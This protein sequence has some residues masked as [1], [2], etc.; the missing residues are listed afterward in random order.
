MSVAYD[1]TLGV[2]HDGSEAYVSNPFP[3]HG[4]TV[5]LTLRVPSH[6]P[7]KGVYV[8]LLLD[9]EF[10]HRQLMPKHVRGNVHFYAVDVTLEQPRLEYAFKLMTDDGAYYYTTNGISRADSPL[11]YDFVLLAGYQAPHWVRDAV[12]YQIFPDRFCNGNPANDV[13][14]GE[15]ERE[16]A[17]TRKLAWGDTPIPWIKGRSVDFF[18]G[19]LEGITQNLGYLEALGVNALYLTPIWRAASN[20][21]Y[22]ASSFD[23]VDA[24]LGGNSALAELRSAL[25]ERQMR[26]VLDITPNHV[27]VTHDWFIAAQA[28]PNAPTAEHFFYDPE[29][30]YF[31][32][33]LGV[34]SLIKLNYTSPRLRDA[35]YRSESS[36]LR[37][38]L[39]PPYRIDG[40]RL[41]VANMTGNLKM[42]QLD[43]DVWREMRPILK[44]D[45]PNLYLLGE[46]FQD[47]TPHTQGEE[48]DATMNY[49]GFN[50]PM[51]RWL[52]GED[53]GVA[54]GKGW[55]DTV[56]LPS[57]ALAQQ[58]RA[59]MGAV[60]Y[61]IALQQFNQL[62]SH[63][64]TRILHVVEGDKAL[65]VLGIAL[66]MG[67]TGVPCLYYGGEVGMTGGKDPDN[68][69]CML[70][71][72][73]TWDK[74]LLMRTQRLIS[75]RKSSPA[76]KH[77]GFQLLYAEGDT[78]A[79]LREAVSQRVLVV[80]HRGDALA[81]LR[82]PLAHGGIADGTTLFDLLTDTSY[83]ANN[84]TIVLKDVAHG[85]AF[86]LE[87]LS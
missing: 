61:V 21:R 8:R 52:G 67:F 16:G 53:I 56:R 29:R 37:R 32:T 35:M 43:H 63:D 54:D 47:A 12:F 4:E 87:V 82:L 7:V 80:G 78:V 65:A 34:P 86:L 2:H 75:I 46:Y 68:R 27:G 74:D 48:L 26:L 71:D 55:G 70:W 73:S 5:T 30:Q 42:N 84:G 69:R 57:E 23:E 31:E 50:T 81:E 24:H 62:D 39:K 25:D 79:F 58:W 72:E 64:V 6:A 18:G 77:G 22:D 3:A 36:A 83:V 1:W 11:F 51:R 9:G 14:D 13:Q 15:W 17:Q 38:W 66:L 44:G 20:H 19:D 49:Q 41:D 28:D 76:L 59:F 33:W 85:Q 40:W 60:P 10:F 45:N